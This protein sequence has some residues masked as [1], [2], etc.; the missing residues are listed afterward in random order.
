MRAALQQQNLCKQAV[1]LATERDARVGFGNE[2]VSAQMRHF[3]RLFRALAAGFQIDK[4][5]LSVLHRNLA[6]GHRTVFR[7][8][9]NFNMVIPHKFLRARRQNGVCADGDGIVCP[10]RPARAQVAVGYKLRF[11]VASP[12]KAGFCRR[13]FAAAGKRTRPAA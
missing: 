5:G 11:H 10:V 6:T 9:D 4:H 2:E 8:A 1:E 12:L 7:P 13:D 3:L